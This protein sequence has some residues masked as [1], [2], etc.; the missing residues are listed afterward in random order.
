MNPPRAPSTPAGPAPGREQ[1]VRWGLIMGLANLVPRVAAALISSSVTL[2]T[3]ALRSAMETLA[4]GCSWYTVRRLARGRH[5]GYEYGLGKLENMTSMLI[6]GAMS[7]T[8]AIMG[9]TSV[10]RLYHP[11]AVRHLGLGLVI[12]VLAGILNWKLWHQSRRAAQAEPSPLMESQWRLMRNKFL[13][14]ASVV[15]TLVLNLALRERPFA[16]Y[17]DP[18]ASLLL[19]GFICFSLYGMLAGSW[20]ALLDKALEENHQL[21]ILKHLVAFEPHYEQLHDIRTRRAG[22]NVFIEVF[23]EF[24]GGQRMAEV[25]D[26]IEAM[27]AAL[28]RDIPGSHVAIVPARHRPGQRPPP[29][30]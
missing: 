14:N 2:Y 9:A 30:K 21:L 23:M 17:I 25:Q 5:A 27:Q 12:S 18:V 11:V 20:S 8:V 10:Y 16:L 19:C 22:N 1:A 29:A 4:N 15:A 3:D 24:N 6:V 28:E 7:I 13:A 26:R